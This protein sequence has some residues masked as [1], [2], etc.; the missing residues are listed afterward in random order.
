MKARC[1]DIS[2]SKLSI[3]LLVVWMIDDLRHLDDQG[4]V[5]SPVPRGDVGEAQAHSE[6][7]LLADGGSA[8]SCSEHVTARHQTA[9]T[10]LKYGEILGLD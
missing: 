5:L 1:K 9:A 3:V 2:L 8:V 4:P 6:L 7:P 10:N